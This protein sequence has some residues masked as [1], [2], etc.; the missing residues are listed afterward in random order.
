MQ[1]V[2]NRDTDP[3]APAYRARF[4]AKTSSWR[5]ARLP[6]SCSMPNRISGREPGRSW[7][8]PRR[9]PAGRAAAAAARRRRG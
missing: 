7:R 6:Q 9:R 1:R 2:T 8:A 4:N 3:G 5:N